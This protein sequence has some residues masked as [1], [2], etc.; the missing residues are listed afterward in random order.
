MAS[1]HAGEPVHPILE[2]YRQIGRI[3][4]ATAKPWEVVGWSNYLNP[5][6]DTA[7]GRER[8]F[9]ELK[10]ALQEMV[11]DLVEQTRM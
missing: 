6:Y 8:K 7:A 9:E 4:P 5:F 11:A 1:I 3:S 2:T 10:G